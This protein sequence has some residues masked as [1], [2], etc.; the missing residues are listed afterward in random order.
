MFRL[1]VALPIATGVNWIVTASLCSGRIANGPEPESNAKGGASAARE[2]VSVLRGLRLW[3]FTTLV[4]GVTPIP[5]RPKS[6]G[7]ATDSAP[8]GVG[9][10]VGDGVGVVVGVGVG[11]GGR[12]AVEVAV[13]VGWVYSSPRLSAEAAT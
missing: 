6:I 5:T 7:V 11:G 12:G 3:M 2:M 8:P 1:P 9:V 4:L 13:A 10:A